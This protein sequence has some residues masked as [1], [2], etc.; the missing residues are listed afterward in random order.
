MKTPQQIF[1]ALEAE[2]G[3]YQGRVLLQNPYPADD[4]ETF[5]A[6]SVVLSDIQEL[7]HYDLCDKEGYPDAVEC[8]EMQWEIIDHESGD[9]ADS[10]NWDNFEVI[11][12]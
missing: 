5:V 1:N 8:D 2:Y 3:E 6:R 12:R 10:C 4:G 9:W 11:S 7:Q